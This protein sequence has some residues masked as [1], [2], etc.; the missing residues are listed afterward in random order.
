MKTLIWMLS[1]ACLTLSITTS[2]Q[3]AHEKVEHPPVKTNENW[4][5][6]FQATTI[7]QKHD[8]FGASYTGPNSL[9]RDEP[10]RTTYTGT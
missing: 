6:H 7:S 4:A 10:F 9:V 5:I 2:G 1:I 8:V 3:G